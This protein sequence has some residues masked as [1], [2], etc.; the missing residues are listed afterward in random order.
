MKVFIVGNFKYGN[1]ETSYLNAFEAI[2]CEVIKF[3]EKNECIVNLKGLFNSWFIPILNKKLISEI[4]LYKP[5]LILVIKG[6][7][8]LPE[9]LIEIKKN[10]NVILCIFNP[11]NPFNL[12]KGASN[13]LIRKSIPYYDFY[14]IWG[15]FLIPKLKEA[16]VRNVEYLPF[17]FDPLLHFPIDVME[18]KKKIY[19][20]DIAFIGSWDKERE[21]WLECL[22]E[23]D[24][25]IW[26]GNW[27]KLK[28]NSPL[29]KKWKG[30]TV[31]GKDFADVCNSSKIVLNL[32]R[33]QN[34]D[35]HNMRTFEVPACKG[36]MLTKR[37]K[38]QCE[39]F[40]EEKEIVCFETKEELRMKVDKYLCNDSKRS[41][42]SMA[43]NKKVQS[44]TYFNRAK[45]ILEVCSSVKV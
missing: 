17:A 4:K 35:A 29:R 44:H 9:T 25:V 21:E 6:S 34:A 41:Q 32:I 10:N 24:L 19:G 22:E 42:I 36:F 37:T 1:L 43:G 5:E 39:F 26:G 8:I 16:G 2:G 11:D 45:K 20:S 12:N 13:D 33:K 38:E 27:E 28:W 3:D 15:K 31:I 40:D 18:E 30:R 23:Y 7:F 14:F